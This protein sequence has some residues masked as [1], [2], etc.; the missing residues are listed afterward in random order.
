MFSPSSS[1]LLLLICDIRSSSSFSYHFST[2]F[3]SSCTGLRY[4][5]SLLYILPLP[6]YLHAVVYVIFRFLYIFLRSILSLSSYLRFSCQFSIISQSLSPPSMIFPEHSLKFSR[7]YFEFPQ[8]ILKFSR[9]FS[10]LFS[11]LSFSLPFSFYFSVIPSVIFS[12]MYEFPQHSLQFFFH[13]Q[14]LFF[15]HHSVVYASPRHSSIISQTLRPPR[16]IILGIYTVTQH[17]LKSS[18]GNFPRLSLH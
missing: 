7:L 18:Q 17:I 3:L 13:F 11:G 5:S 10:W 6:F 4:F 1:F 12:G 8:H 9:L 14:S 16:T 2:S 15:Y